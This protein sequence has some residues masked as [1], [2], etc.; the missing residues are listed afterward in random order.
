MLTVLKSPKRIIR[1][2]I[3]QIKKWHYIQKIEY[4][5]EEDLEDIREGLAEIQR[6]E[7]VSH[8]EVRKKARL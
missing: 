4:Y 2:R 1:K 6:G 3:R 7:V 8:E 5:S